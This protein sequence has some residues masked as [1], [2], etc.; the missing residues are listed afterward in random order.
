MR[1]HIEGRKYLKNGE[2]KTEPIQRIEYKERGVSKKE[3]RRRKEALMLALEK[4]D[5][6]PE[7]AMNALKEAMTNK[8]EGI[9][10][11]S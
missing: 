5:Q 6:S 2:I 11:T 10:A 9:D 1:S 7:E 8:K 3:R 4:V